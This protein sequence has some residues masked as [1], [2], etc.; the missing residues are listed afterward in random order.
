MDQVVLLVVH[1]EVEAKP[2]LTARALGHKANLDG[3]AGPGHK[4]DISTVALGHKDDLDGVR[5][6]V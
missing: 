3:V 4:A 5:A 6:L 1:H 2:T